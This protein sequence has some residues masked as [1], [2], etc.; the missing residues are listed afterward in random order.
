MNFIL[1]TLLKL[2]Y[3][4]D[5]FFIFSVK[6]GFI[7]FS[8]VI[9]YRDSRVDP[10]YNTRIKCYN[11]CHSKTEDSRNISDFFITI[12]T[13]GLLDLD[14]RRGLFPTGPGDSV[15]VNDYYFLLKSGFRRRNSFSPSNEIQYFSETSLRQSNNCTLTRSS[16]DHHYRGGLPEQMGRLSRGDKGRGRGKGRG[17]CVRYGRSWC[18]CYQHS[19]YI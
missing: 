1:F 15:Q 10:D 17:V 8:S 14:S 5:K 3:K 19:S 9:K 4:L 2:T 7:L 13:S 11:K 12:T 18:T 6:E 16:K